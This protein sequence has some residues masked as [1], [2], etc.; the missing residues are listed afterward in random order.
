VFTDD[1]AIVKEWYLLAVTYLVALL[2][3]VVGAQ[4]EIRWWPWKGSRLRKRLFFAEMKARSSLGTAALASWLAGLHTVRGLDLDFVQSLQNAG[5]TEQE[6]KMFETSCAGTPAGDSTGAQSRSFSRS[7]F[8]RDVRTMCMCGYLRDA[9]PAD[10]SLKP[11]KGRH[12]KC[13]DGVA[14][15]P[16]REY[17]CKDVDLLSLVPLAELNSAYGNPTDKATDVWGWTDPETCAEIAMIALDSGTAFVDVTD[18]VNYRYFGKLPCHNEGVTPWRDIK[19]F[20]HYAF[21]VSEHKDHGMQ[22]FDLKRL[23]SP[24]VATVAQSFE[25]LGNGGL[26]FTEDA[27]YDGFG[28]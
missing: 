21:I 19:T 13:I 7:G 25:K 23:T 24:T 5:R 28:Q 16:E 8:K 2:L 27:H 6:Q 20:G 1:F 22:V 9:L 3:V 17:P 15:T 12:V 18:P 4:S 26:K 11:V 14:K 10:T